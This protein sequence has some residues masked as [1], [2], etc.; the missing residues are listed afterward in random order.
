MYKNE[1][2]LLK[3]AEYR[4]NE[5]AN[6]EK[7]LEGYA[8]VFDRTT[9]LGWFTEVVK[10][11]AFNKTLADGADVRALFNHD[12]NYILGRVKSGTL[13]L[14]IDDVGLRF[15]VVLPPTQYADDLWESVKRG[16][17]DQSS[18]GF[19]VIKERWTY[20]NEGT[21]DETA[22]RELLEVKLFD[23]SPVTFPAYEETAVTARDKFG[24]DDSLNDV[25]RKIKRGKDLTDGEKRVYNEFKEKFMKKDETKDEN[26][27]VSLLRMKLDLIETENQILGA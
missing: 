17:V 8:A 20:Q 1:R 7:I 13:T 4:A 18:F 23:V 11:S 6:G 22:L 2:R 15:K 26:L 14:S 24:I 27:D 21:Q 16:D 5:G 12:S 9:D 19:Q 25:M 10:P 3:S